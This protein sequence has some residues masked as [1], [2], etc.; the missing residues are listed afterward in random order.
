MPTGNAIPGPARS[1]RGIAFRCI[2]ISIGA[3]HGPRCGKDAPAC[4]RHARTTHPA[5]PRPPNDLEPSRRPTRSDR[6]GATPGE[7]VSTSQSSG[8]ASRATYG[9]QTPEGPA[10][11]TATPLPAQRKTP[12]CRRLRP[13]GTGGEARRRRG[14][15]QTGRQG[16][17]GERPRGEN[18]KRGS[19]GP[20]G[21]PGT[22]SRDQRLE[23]A[24]PQRLERGG[25]NPRKARA[26]QTGIRPRTEGRL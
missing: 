5:R 24:P 19:S 3:A 17:G 13:T 14:P 7:V 4:T 18:P 20:P 8:E 21:P 23:E 9:S 2:P 10:P 15:G 25:E 12:G 26:G 11:E 16:A 1:E 22:P 6:G